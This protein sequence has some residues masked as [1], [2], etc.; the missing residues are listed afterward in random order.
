M[1]LPATIENKL[2]SDLQVTTWNRQIDNQEPLRAIVKDI[3]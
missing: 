2:A 3:I 1:T